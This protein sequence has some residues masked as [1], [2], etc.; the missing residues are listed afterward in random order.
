M[1]W[2]SFHR[3]IFYK[4][5][6]TL[7][8]CRFVKRCVNVSGWIQSKHFRSPKYKGTHIW[9]LML[10]HVLLAPW[11]NMMRTSNVTLNSMRLYTICFLYMQMHMQVCWEG[12]CWAAPLGSAAR[13]EYRIQ[14]GK[15]LSLQQYLQRREDLVQPEEN[16]NGYVES[17]V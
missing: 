1:T 10:H 13:D 9:S 15:G 6:S 11:G 17:V 4:F 2:C 12:M 7:S 5:L 16:G 3:R 8:Y 14:Y